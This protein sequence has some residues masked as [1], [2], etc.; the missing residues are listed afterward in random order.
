M[1]ISKYLKQNRTIKRLAITLL[2]GFFIATLAGLM[3]AL[4]GK[5][6]KKALSIGYLYVAALW[7]FYG[8]LLLIVD[9]IKLIYQKIIKR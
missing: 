7:A 8:T 6:P 4:S 2:A 9:L 5:D 1:I 3:L